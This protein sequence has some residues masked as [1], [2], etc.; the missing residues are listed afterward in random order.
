MSFLRLSQKLLRCDL[1]ATISQC[2]QPAWDY[3]QT[4]TAA[5][6][7]LRTLGARSLGSLPAM[8]Y[9]PRKRPSVRICRCRAG[10]NDVLRFVMALRRSTRERTDA[11]EPA[12][13]VQKGKCGTYK[14]GFFALS[15]NK[16]QIFCPILLHWQIQKRNIVPKNA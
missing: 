3:A 13:K 5:G 11:A 7:L 9:I 12:F 6:A 16:G 2:L 15:T 14:S 8:V 4:C 1:Q 10:H